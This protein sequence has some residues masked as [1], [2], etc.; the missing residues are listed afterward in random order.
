MYLRLS[1][2]ALRIFSTEEL[3]FATV[4]NCLIFIVDLYQCRN[5][6][7]ITNANSLA[8]EAL[9]S[10]D[11][12]MLNKRIY[13]LTNIR[14]LCCLCVNMVVAMHSLYIAIFLASA[15]NQNKEEAK[16]EDQCC[17]AK[18]TDNAVLLHDFWRCVSCVSC[19]DIG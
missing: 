12:L 2:Y 6:C 19:S 14:L 4:F 7:A 13:L 5:I 15:C 3:A 16:M 8:N 18:D 9:K 10:K 11:Q 17:W 1:V